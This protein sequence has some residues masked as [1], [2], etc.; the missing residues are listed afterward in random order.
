MSKR[1]ANNQAKWEKFKKATALKRSGKKSDEV[2]TTMEYITV[3]CLSATVEGKCQKYSRIGP[4]TMV[5]FGDELTL[6]N[7]KAACIKHFKRPSYMECDLLAGE[8][9]PS[10]T[11]IGQI[12]NWKVLHVRFVESVENISVQ[13]S[14]SQS[15]RRLTSSSNTKS[16]HPAA[17]SVSMSSL[18]IFSSSVGHSASRADPPQSKMPASVSMA[19]MLNMGKIIPP[20]K[21]IVTVYLEEF[22]VDERK[23]MAWSFWGTAFCRKE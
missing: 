8:R 1:K 7:V 19:A 10:F 3:Q 20:S 22:S 2:S 11:D 9:G 12:K 21:E 14:S 18:P 23:S 4:L 6:D 17:L 13:A 16:S 5:P 15:R